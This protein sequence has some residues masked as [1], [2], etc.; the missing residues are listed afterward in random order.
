[1]DTDPTRSHRAGSRESPDPDGEPGAD[2]ITKSPL[3]KKA[4]IGDVD[5]LEDA[6]P[7]RKRTRKTQTVKWDLVSCFHEPA[8]RQLRRQ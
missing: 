2:E 1:M 7:G 6:V 3:K 4:R 8:Y 5:D